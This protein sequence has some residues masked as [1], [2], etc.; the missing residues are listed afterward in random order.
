[1][2]TGMELRADVSGS[3]PAGARFSRR[4]GEVAMLIAAGCSDQEMARTLGISP[5]TARAH[6][7]ILR[8][9]LG[10]VRRRQIP[11]A[12]RAATGSDV[13]GAALL[14]ADARASRQEPPAEG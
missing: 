10:V 2:L 13:L 7:D 12:F 8:R 1:M 14:A 11:L 9:K 4:Q 6:A 5:R 3:A